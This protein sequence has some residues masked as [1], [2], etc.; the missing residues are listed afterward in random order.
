MRM[1]FKSQLS[2]G[3][4]KGIGI[5]NNMNNKDKFIDSLLHLNFLTTAK[6]VMTKR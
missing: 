2:D 5:F 4:W 3:L 6:F 1:S